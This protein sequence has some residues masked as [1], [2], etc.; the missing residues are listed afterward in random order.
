[1]ENSFDTSF[2]P[3]QPLVRVEGAPH[4]KEPINLALVLAIIIFFV[5]LVVAGGVYLYKLQIDKGVQ[6]KELALQAEEK[7]LNIDEINSYKRIDTRITTAKTLLRGHTVFSIILNLLEETA[8][9]NIG[10]TSL[11]YGG[12]SKNY[13]LSLSGEA[14]NYGAVYFQ[15]QAWRSMIPLVKKVE[16]ISLTPSDTT[17]VVSFSAEITIDP[18]YTNYAQL[19]QEEEQFRKIKETQSQS[20]NPPSGIPPLPPSGTIST[21]P[22]NVL[23]SPLGVPPNSQSNSPTR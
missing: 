13:K 8:A 5:T 1:M 22:A 9:Q 2:I 18:A 16:I 3:Q 11:S 6:A 17:G 7:N 20:I 19:A 15:A 10:L 21:P 14:L 12:D 23:L 4:R